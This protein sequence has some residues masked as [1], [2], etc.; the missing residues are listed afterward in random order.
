[1]NVTSLRSLRIGNSNYRNNGLQKQLEIELWSDS[2]GG[3][4]LTKCGSLRMDGT[5]RSKWNGTLRACSTEIAFE[6]SGHAGRFVCPIQSEISIEIAT[7]WIRPATISVKGFESEL[8]F[9]FPK[10]LM[11]EGARSSDAVVSLSVASTLVELCAFPSPHYSNV[12]GSHNLSPD[13]T[14]FF[15]LNTDLS[16]VSNDTLG[17]VVIATALIG[18]RFYM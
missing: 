15:D 7:N 10:T 16:F 17:L 3:G 8:T 1:M 18:Y 5:F 13:T 12:N 2:D 9:T 6:G 14:S 11:L 4:S